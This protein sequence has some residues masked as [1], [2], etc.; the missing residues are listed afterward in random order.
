MFLL[1]MA[2][3]GDL[4]AGRELEADDEGAFLCRGAEQN[5]DLCPLR[6]RRG[7]R[8]A[9]DLV[10]RDHHVMVITRNGGAGANNSDAATIAAGVD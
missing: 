8:I 5:R 7:P 6:K 10:G 3:R 4:V 2:M 9:D 1:R